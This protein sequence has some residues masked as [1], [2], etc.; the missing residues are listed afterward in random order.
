MSGRIKCENGDNSKRL[1]RLLPG[2][3]CTGDVVQRRSQLANV[4]LARVGYRN[5]HKTLL[6]RML[7]GGQ[8]LDMRLRMSHDVDEGERWT[9]LRDFRENRCE[10]I[11]AGVLLR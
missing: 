5:L 7:S 8:A 9:L 6:A 11:A 4:G 1:C 10:G 2:L 3:V